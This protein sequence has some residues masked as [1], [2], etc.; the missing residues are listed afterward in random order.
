MPAPGPR[1]Q[2]RL[3]PPGQPVSNC[4]N[5]SPCPR[6][7]ETDLKRCDSP[8]MSPALLTICLND[9][10][11][12]IFRA[13]GAQARWPQRQPCVHVTQTRGASAP[14]GPAKGDGVVRIVL[15]PTFIFRQSPGAV[16][17]PP[18]DSFV[19]RVRQSANEASLGAPV[20]SGGGLKRSEAC[21]L[22]RT[23]H[24]PSASWKKQYYLLCLVPDKIS[25]DFHRLG[26]FL[27]A[28]KRHGRGVIFCRRNVCHCSV[29][30]GGSR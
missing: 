21:S 2:R 17:P 25:T 4:L 3:L 5:D 9:R 13:F 1:L 12:T 11:A 22:R 8:Q 18:P 7:N 10:E 26:F 28:D 30:T 29:Q 23:T 24:L 19:L 27:R 16:R 15:C 6:I 14:P 20:D